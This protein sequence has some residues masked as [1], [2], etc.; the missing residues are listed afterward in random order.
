MCVCFCAELLCFE[1]FE[2]ALPYCHAMKMGASLG[3]C[4]L[5]LAVHELPA[6]RSAT[7]LDDSELSQADKRDLEFAF[8]VV[9]GN[10]ETLLIVAC[11]SESEKMEWMAAFDKVWKKKR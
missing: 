1:A 6:S 8:R 5:P 3:K 10:L 7:D 4:H 9:D 2:S 11:K